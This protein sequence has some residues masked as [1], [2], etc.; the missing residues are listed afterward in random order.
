MLTFD[1]RGVGVFKTTDG[2]MVADATVQERR[3]TAVEAADK[4]VFVSGHG[5]C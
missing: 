4:S 2:R 5:C 3:P 1:L